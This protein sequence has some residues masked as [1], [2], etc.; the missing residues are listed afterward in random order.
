MRWKEGHSCFTGY[1]RNSW[2]WSLLDWSLCLHWLRSLAM[3][4]FPRWRIGLVIGVTQT[5]HRVVIHCGYHGEAFPEDRCNSC[6]RVNLAPPHCEIFSTHRNENRHVRERE[7]ERERM[8]KKER[9]QSLGSVFKYDVKPVTPSSGRNKLSEL[10]Y[11]QGHVR[12]CLMSL[13]QQALQ[14]GST[15]SPILSCCLI[16]G[17]TPSSLIRRKMDFCNKERSEGK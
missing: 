13:L 7:R 3:W 17:W 6:F 5:L 9:E 16:Y 4:R 11:G 1:D 14:H 12:R 10:L 2:L 15:L 8:C